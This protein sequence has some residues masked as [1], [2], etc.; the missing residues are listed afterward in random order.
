MERSIQQL[1][2]LTQGFCDAADRDKGALLT[3]N[4]T[5]AESLLEE[6][7]FGRLEIEAICAIAKQNGLV[8]KVSG[9]GMGRIVH[10][11]YWRYRAEGRHSA[12]SLRYSWTR[13]HKFS[14]YFKEEGRLLPH[15]MEQ[16]SI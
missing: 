16:S 9:A 1:G 13:F 7:D 5:V 3:A 15:S 8:A 2:E 14:R 12:S 6:L 4:F 10:T 11:I